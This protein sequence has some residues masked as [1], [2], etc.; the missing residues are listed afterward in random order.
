[1][2]AIPVL[3]Y[4]SVSGGSSGWIARYTVTPRAFARHMQLVADS[5]RT[6]MTVSG[7][8][9]ALRGDRPLPPHPVVITFDDGFAD[10]LTEAAPVL[11]RHGLPS[12]V[13]VTTGVVGGSS[14]GGDRMLE[15]PQVEELA[16]LGH[17]IGGHTHTH[18]QLDT[19][20]RTVAGREIRVCKQV[21]EQRLGGAVRSFAYPFGYS[22]ARVRRLVRAAGYESA[23]S[24]KNAFSPP[25]DP[26]YSI[27]RLAVTAHTTDARIRRWLGGGGARVA[28]PGD[29]ALERT[30]R[31][32]RRTRS[33]VSPP[34]P[35]EPVECA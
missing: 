6:P 18:P 19:V 14:P 1:M 23:C 11:A 27:A 7:L 28:F 30:W 2:T 22:D 35:W 29:T 5:G 10:T 8:R 17:E 34:V 33:W 15:W 4:H 16:A 20:S 12:T 25:T 3:L 32:V 21:L 24:V 13:Y 31:A 9:S 26:A